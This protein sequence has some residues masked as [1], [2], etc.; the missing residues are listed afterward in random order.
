MADD[1]GTV[2]DL[3]GELP[4]PRTLTAAE[5]ADLG[6]ELAAYHA[7]FAPFFRRSEQR[8]W[9]EVYLRGLLTADVPRKN[10]EA[11]ALRLL[12]AGPG[13]ESRVRA[14]QQFVGEGGWDDAAILAAHQRL[15]GTHVVGGDAGRGGWRPA[16]RRQRPAQAGEPLGRRG[17]PVVRR[18]DARRAAV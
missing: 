15:A 9:A 16:H 14:L 4:P 10:T 3:G 5:V 7:Y 13:A 2:S 8:V 6:E 17:A 18:A 11:M 1:G 12:G